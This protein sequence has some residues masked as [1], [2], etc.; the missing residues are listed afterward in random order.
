MAPK[1]ESQIAALSLSEPLDY[2]K[3]EYDSITRGWRVVCVKTNGIKFQSTSLVRHTDT[4]L[5]LAFYAMKHASAESWVAVGEN[6]FTLP[7]L[8]DAAMRCTCAHAPKYPEIGNPDCP[9][10]GKTT[11]TDKFLEGCGHHLSESESAYYDS[12]PHMIRLCKR[13]VM[14]ER[15]R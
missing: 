14:E 6:T 7:E 2:P 13:C 12:R 5:S 11:T 8:W 15:A 4:L 1:T 9:V 3:W 10:H